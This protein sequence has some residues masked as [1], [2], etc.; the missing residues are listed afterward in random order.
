M[1]STKRLRSV[2][3]SI[4]HHAM[5]G[6]CYVHPHLGQARKLLGVERISVDLLHS[7]VESLPKPLPR[8]IELSTDALSEKFFDL[9]ASESLS[10]SDVVSA[11][12]TFFYKGDCT[13]PEACLVRIQTTSGAESEDAVGHDGR[14][15]EILR[16][17]KLLHATRETRAREQ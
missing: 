12:A 17:D 8:A 11:I 16:D 7:T 13:W 10:R 6:L 2:V 3:H 5:S 14:R 1:R 4:A 9:L 15:A